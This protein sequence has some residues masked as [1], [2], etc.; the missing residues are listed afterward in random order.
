ME[1]LSMKYQQ[2]VN[3]KTVSKLQNQVDFLNKEN[4]RI[5]TQL[6]FFTKDKSVTD[7]LE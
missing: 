1:K 7:H 3:D 2:D 5:Q 6:D 4:H